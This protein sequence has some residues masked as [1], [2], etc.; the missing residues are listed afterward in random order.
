LCPE[1][2]IDCT[3]AIRKSQS[4]SGVGAV[5]GLVPHHALVGNGAPFVDAFGAM[6]PHGTWPGKFIAAVAMTSGFGALIGWTLVDAELPRAVANDGLFPKPLG[7][8]DR[9]GN[10]W[11]SIVTNAVL[12]SLLMLWR[13][14]SSS[15][16]TV[17][18]YMVNLTVVTVAIPYFSSAC[19]QLTYLLSKRRRVQGRALARDLTVAGA[20]ALFSMWVNFA[21]GT[22]PSTRPSSRCSSASSCTC[23]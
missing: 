3:R 17:F 23:S 19:A 13:Y 8:S 18:T 1:A 12:P 20:G 22:T 5:M 14:T 11:F 2:L 15:G 10:A 21:S 6:F 9:N 16:L 7:W 4:S